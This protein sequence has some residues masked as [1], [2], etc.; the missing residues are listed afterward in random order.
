MTPS[1]FPLLLTAGPHTAN[2]QQMGQCLG[3]VP[4]LAVTES[5]APGFKVA[6]L[7]W[8]RAAPGENVAGIFLRNRA[9]I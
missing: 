5:L 4:S 3:H 1:P 6:I 2:H 8:I 7:P 9:N